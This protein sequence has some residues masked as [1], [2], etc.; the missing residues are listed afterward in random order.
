MIALTCRYIGEMMRSTL[1]GTALWLTVATTVFAQPADGWLRRLELPNHSDQR[2]LALSADGTLAVGRVAGGVGFARWWWD[3]TSPSVV[4]YGVPFYLAEAISAFRIGGL[5]AAIT[6]DAYLALGTQLFPMAGA[7]I[8][9]YR[10]VSTN[11][12]GVICVGHS[13]ST[14]IG[15]HQ[16]AIWRNNSVVHLTALNSSGLAPNHS[17]TGGI[18]TDVSENGEVIVGWLPYGHDGLGWPW[19]WTEHSGFTFYS[20][21][22]SANPQVPKSVHVSNDGLC[23]IW[24]SPSGIFQAVGESLQTLPP[25]PNAVIVPSIDAVSA[26]GHV[27]SA[28]QYVWRSGVGWARWIDVLRSEGGFHVSDSTRID[29]IVGISTDGRTILGT[30]DRCGSSA[31][32]LLI[33]LPTVPL[34]PADFNQSGNLSVQDLFEFLASYF[35]GALDADWNG[36]CDLSVQDV[37]DFLFDYFS[38][39]Q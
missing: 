16:P 5:P 7:G 8:P 13:R 28:Q 4:Q 12:D 38:A 33:R 24:R 27:V 39:C 6:P 14:T 23:V 35:S 17:A 19:R 15:T 37:F 30:A 36:S 9:D 1:T 31:F 18:A 20:P 29:K 10:I 34:C 26:E 21:A 32:S 11:D 22:C 2:P 25:V 3:G